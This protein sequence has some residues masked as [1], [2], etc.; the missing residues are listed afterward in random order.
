M[1][2]LD[3]AQ[4]LSEGDLRYPG[5]RVVAVCQLGVMVG[6]AT[7]FIYSFSLMMKPLQQAFGWNR[8]QI[9]QAFSLAAISV[10]ICSPVMGK[11]F[12]RFEPRK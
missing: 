8:E 11:L 7:V 10:A 1:K 4:V 6:F 9:S 5:W 12:D 3:H 2:G